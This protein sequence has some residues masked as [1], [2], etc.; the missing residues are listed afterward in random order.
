MLEL[1]DTSQVFQGFFMK[2]DKIVYNIL[3][4]ENDLGENETSLWDGRSQ[5]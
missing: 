4:K 3:S 5:N 1:F 2:N